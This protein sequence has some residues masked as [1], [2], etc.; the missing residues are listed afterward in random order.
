VTA[1][2]NSREDVVAAAGRLFAERGYHGTSMRDLGTELGMLG[3][4]L[5]SHVTSK[6]DLLVEVVEKGARLFAD[7]AAKAT[8]AGGT[9][10][11][12]LQ[13]LIAGHVDVVIEHQDEVRTFLNEARFLEGEHRGRIVAARDAYEL[14]FR[15]AIADGIN[16]G[17]L[18]WRGGSKAGGDLRP[19][20]PQRTRTLVSPRGSARPRPARRPRLVVPGPGLIGH[21]PLSQ[22]R[23]PS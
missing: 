14:E 19:L 18:P 3:S 9:G 22:T 7:S 10:A 16:D 12:R 11:Q 20:D 23:L 13:A 1:T 15:R 2:R 4:S 8:A 17:S 6:E 21:L 5:Y